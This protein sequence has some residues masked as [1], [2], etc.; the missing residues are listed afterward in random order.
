M[1]A[2]YA[3]VDGCFSTNSVL[4][5]NV[6]VHGLTSSSNFCRMSHI[7]KVMAA[8]RMQNNA[9]VRVCIVA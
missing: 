6:E 3:Q 4:R 9:N 8:A 7:T 1:Y 5:R 2:T